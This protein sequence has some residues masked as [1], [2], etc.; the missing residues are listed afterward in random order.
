MLS[1]FTLRCSGQC[2]VI[3]KGALDWHLTR[4]SPITVYGD[5]CSRQAL[6]WQLEEG[7]LI[8][9]R[10]PGE[11]YLNWVLRVEEAFT[12]QRRWMWGGKFHTL[13]VPVKR[14][15][16]V[17]SDFLVYILEVNWSH[18]PPGLYKWKNWW[19]EAYP[20]TFYIYFLLPKSFN[21]DKPGIQKCVLIPS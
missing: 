8:S 1:T 5:M 14:T 16:K 18:Y 7:W 9:V 19:I 11:G 10:S 3:R 13:P 20:C 12:R 6:Q 17:L 4:G 21:D 2:K 15:A